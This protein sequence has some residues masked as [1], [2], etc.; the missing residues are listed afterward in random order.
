MKKLRALI[1]IEIIFLSNFLWAVDGDADE[2]IS[3]WV[4]SW[5]S[6]KIGLSLSS[7]DPIYFIK[8][9]KCEKILEVIEIDRAT[10]IREVCFALKKKYTNGSLGGY[11]KIMISYALAYFMYG[12]EEAT[13]E[14]L[15]ILANNLRFSYLADNEH[16]NSVSNRTPAKTESGR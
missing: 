4:D 12:R 5:D 1:L 6:N 11:K 16:Q 13:I 7:N 8:Q 14:D 9:H 10:N 3:K 2:F 15:E